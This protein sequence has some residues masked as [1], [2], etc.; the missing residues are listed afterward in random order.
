MY[1]ARRSTVSGI[2][3]VLVTAAALICIIGCGKKKET[4]VRQGPGVGM[5]AGVVLSVGGL[6][7]KSF[8]DLAHAGLMK[9]AKDLGIRPVYGQPEQMAEDEKYLR[10]YAEQGFDLIVGVGFLMKTAVE[11]VAGEFPESR[12]AI[13]DCI[14]EEPNVASLVFREHEGSFLVGAL[15]SMK[16]RTGKV[17]FVGG[18]DSPLIHRFEVGYTEGAKYVNPDTDVFIAYVGSH[19]GA[20]HDPVRGKSLAISQFDRGAEVVFHA[21][22]SS[23]N[24]VI[25]AAAERGLYAIGVDANQNYVAPGSVLTSMIKRVDV[26]VFRTIEEVVHGRFKG[27]LREFG[28]ADDG[29]GYALDEHNRDVITPEMLARVEELKRKIVSGEIRVTDYYDTIAP[30]ES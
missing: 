23:G 20:F 4:E 18:M 29:V 27:G 6:G 16:T 28:L 21:A 1:H 15:A 8:N 13:I 14:V 12:F 2:A 30:D 26:A 3:L 5:T 19:T 25:D 17:G 7:D 22:G 9:A 11:E 24:G 10:D